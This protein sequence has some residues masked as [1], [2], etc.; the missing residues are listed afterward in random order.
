[1]VVHGGRAVHTGP[2]NGRVRA[3]EWAPPG[4]PGR[5]RADPRP[6]RRGGRASVARPPPFRPRLWRRRRRRRR[7]RSGPPRPGSGTR[8]PSASPPTLRTRARR[9]AGRPPLLTHRQ[10][11]ASHDRVTATTAAALPMAWIPGTARIGSMLAR[12]V[13]GPSTTTSAAAIASRTPGAG[14]AATP[15]S[16]RTPRTTARP[17]PGT[18]H[19]AGSGRVGDDAGGHLVVARQRAA[20][21]EHHDIGPLFIDARLRD[22]AVGRLG[23][24]EAVGLRLPGH[25]RAHPL[26]VDD[27]DA[28]TR[29]RRRTA[30]V[31]SACRARQLR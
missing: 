23:D 15:P 4:D 24:R 10:R 3:R 2:V 11:H 14:V 7:A 21:V 22:Q 19:R 25:D 6:P 30:R 5:P 26:V 28:M 20:E 1:M 13:L 12:G 17:A 31:G 27:Q 29:R 18:P 8:P 16:W 9:P